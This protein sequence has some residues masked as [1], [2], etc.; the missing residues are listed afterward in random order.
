V[1][2]GILIYILRDPSRRRRPGAA[3]TGSAEPPSNA[4]VLYVQQ[5]VYRAGARVGRRG[6]MH[7]CVHVQAVPVRARVRDMRVRG[8]IH[9]DSI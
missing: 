6:N 7:L 8:V 9:H 1:K 5:I 4:L 3:Q 2:E